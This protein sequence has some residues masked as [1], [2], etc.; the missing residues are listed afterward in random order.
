M[1]LSDFSRWLYKHKRPNRIAQFMNRTTALIASWGFT[2]NYL[3]SLEVTGRKSGRTLSLPVVVATVDG[4]RYL[5][6]MLGGDVQ[7]VKNV[8]AAKGRATLRS[9]GREAV[10]LEEIPVEHR[11]PILRAYLQRAPG[12]RPHG[13]TLLSTRMLPWKNSRRSPP[14][15]RSSVLRRSRTNEWLSST[16]AL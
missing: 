13:P 10:R 15:F 7:W 4:Q 2:R 5:V 8:R 1:A 14:R 11:A 6:S 3:M 16:T 9:A 12:A